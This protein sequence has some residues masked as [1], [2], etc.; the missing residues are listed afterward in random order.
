[1][2][3]VGEVIIRICLVIIIYLM[4]IGGIHWRRA[5][6]EANY[7]TLII[8]ILL[9]ILI[10]ILILIL[11]VI[12]IILIILIIIIVIVILVLMI[13]RIEVVV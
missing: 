4:V 3:I 2:S 11:I 12:I 6:V 13:Y 5:V 1:M 10:V 8:L 7:T 9:I